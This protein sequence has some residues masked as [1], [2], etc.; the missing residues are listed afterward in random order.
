MDSQKNVPVLSKIEL[1]L[2]YQD[3]VVFDY[4]SVWADF[5]FFFLILAFLCLL[6]LA[7]CKRPM[8]F[9]GQSISHLLWF[10]SLHVLILCSR[11]NK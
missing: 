5:M 4:F 8:P 6:L 9:V 2:T 1:P 7:T 11:L 10:Y 3:L